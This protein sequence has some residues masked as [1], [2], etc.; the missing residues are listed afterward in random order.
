MARNFK[1]DYLKKLLAVETS[2][3]FMVDVANYLHNPNHAYEYP[4]LHKVVSEGEKGRKICSIVYFKHYDGTGEYIMTTH[5]EPKDVE[6]KWYVV[7][8]KK[9]T[10]LEPC[11][12]FSLAKLIRHAESVRE[13][14]L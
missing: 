10:M 11:N 1:K 3:G 4:T 5:T 6:G 8:D 9:E 7:K 12:R 13:E 14:T 2:N